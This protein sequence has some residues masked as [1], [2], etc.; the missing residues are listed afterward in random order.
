MPVELDGALVV[1]YT[2]TGVFVLPDVGG[3]LR[4]RPVAASTPAEQ[5]V[6]G[7]AGWD[8]EVAGQAPF[9]SWTADR[10]ADFNNHPTTIKKEG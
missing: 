2:A 6:D 5:T 3:T 9:Y 8:L 1:I 7:I 4:L 10:F